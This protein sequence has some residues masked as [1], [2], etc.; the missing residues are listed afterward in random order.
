[1]CLN[2]QVRVA[3]LADAPLHRLLD[4]GPM[5]GEEAR[6]RLMIDELGLTDVMTTP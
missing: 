6:D 2:S 5:A 1:M 4:Q 3:I